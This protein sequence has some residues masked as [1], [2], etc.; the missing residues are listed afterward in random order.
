[1]R[2]GSGDECPFLQTDPTS[3]FYG[4]D[5][6]WADTK[7]RRTVIAEFLTNPNDGT[8]NRDEV[9]LSVTVSWKTGTY[10]NREISVFENLYRW[11]EEGSAASQ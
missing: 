2:G 6:G 4:Y 5:D 10:N 1:M 8:E 3:S 9:R 7:F 11:V